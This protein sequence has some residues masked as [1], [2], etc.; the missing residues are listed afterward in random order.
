VLRWRLLGALLVIAGVG[1]FVAVWS[2]IAWMVY[3]GPTDYLQLLALVLALAL[4][5]AGAR[6]L[7]V[8]R[9]RKRAPP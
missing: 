4:A 3:G 9:T 7:I 5:L 8:S 1:G 2:R 6:L